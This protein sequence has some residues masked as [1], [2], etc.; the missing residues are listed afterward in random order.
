MDR[1]GTAE[2]HLVAVF[3]RT[4]GRSCGEKV[5]RRDEVEGGTPVTV[6]GIC[7]VCPGRQSSHASGHEHE[8]TGLPGPSTTGALAGAG[9][10]DKGKA[11]D[12]AKAGK[13]KK[14]TA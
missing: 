14:N 4:E 3:D 1:C 8:G 11:T 9:G 5:F 10:N 6:Q 7:A 13:R 2:G 12:K